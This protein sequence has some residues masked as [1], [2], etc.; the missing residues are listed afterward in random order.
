MNNR[1]KPRAGTDTII[2]SLLT[3]AGCNRELN[4]DCGKHTQPADPKTLAAKGALT[5]IADGMGGHSAGEVASRI[6]VEVITRVYYADSSAPEAALKKAFQEANREIY[7]ASLVNQSRKGMGT[8]ATALVLQNGSAVCAHVGDSRLYLIR[9]GQIYVMTEEHS[10]VMEMVRRG[11]ISAEKAR[12]HPDKNVIT[13]ALGSAKEIE[14]SAWQQPF[15]VRPG[16]CFLLCSDGLYDLVEDEEIKRVALDEEPAAACDKLIA[17]AKQRG[18]HDNITVGIIRV[19]AA[20]NS[21]SRAVPKTRDLE[22]PSWS[23]TL[24]GVIRSLKKSAKAAWARFSVG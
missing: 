1:K 12:H 11:I 10:V 22:V 15:P 4:E 16:D 13:R 21:N 18:G 19:Q 20:N 7:Q 5:I 2:A 23:A 14:V 24:S 9:G 17:L 6:A 8:T 3:H